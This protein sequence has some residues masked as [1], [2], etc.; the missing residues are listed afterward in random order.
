ML[1]MAESE[2]SADE[3]APAV[4]EKPIAPLVSPPNESVNVPLLGVPVRVPTPNL[5]DVPVISRTVNG[6]VISPVACKKYKLICPVSPFTKEGKSAGNKL[7]KLC[8]S[9]R[10]VMSM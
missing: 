5:T 4:A 9:L 7:V 1:V 3:I 2:L 6:D 10:L 8:A